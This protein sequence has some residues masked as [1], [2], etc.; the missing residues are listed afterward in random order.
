[1]PARTHILTGTREEIIGLLSAIDGD[2]QK[3]VVIVY[4]R[5]PAPKPWSAEEGRGRVGRDGAVHVGL[6]RMSTT[7]VK[8]LYDD[9]RTESPSSDDPH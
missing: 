6:P 3:V 2:I 5:I 4:E 1:V 7:R 8:R 9:S